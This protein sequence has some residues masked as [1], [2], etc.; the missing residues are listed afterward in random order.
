L[1]RDEAN[2]RVVGCSVVDQE[3]PTLKDG[4]P[5]GNGV[6]GGEDG[7]VTVGHYRP[8]DR[9]VVAAFGESDIGQVPSRRDLQDTDL[10]S[11]GHGVG[12]GI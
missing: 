11:S 1:D 4:R 2:G 9:G 3:D 5:H 6:G 10:T 12:G 7:L 8:A